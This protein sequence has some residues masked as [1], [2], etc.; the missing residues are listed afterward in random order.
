MGLKKPEIVLQ[1]DF[2]DPKEYRSSKREVFEAERKLIEEEREQ[3][4]SASIESGEMPPGV[5]GLNPRRQY[6]S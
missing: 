1:E 4:F 6:Q 5:T 3:L 2:Q